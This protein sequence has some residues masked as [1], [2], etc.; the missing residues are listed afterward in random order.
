MKTERVVV[1]KAMAPPVG[2]NEA[3]SPAE[4]L[5]GSSYLVNSHVAETINGKAEEFSKLESLER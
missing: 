3:H 4:T 5:S 2:F 1:I